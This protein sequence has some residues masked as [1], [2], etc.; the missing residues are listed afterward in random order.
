MRNIL[1]IILISVSTS[2]FSQ[3][4]IDT[5]EIKSIRYEWKLDKKTNDST[6]NQILTEYKNGIYKEEFPSFR[7]EHHE[8]P[9]INIFESKS[10]HLNRDLKLSLKIHYFSAMDGEQKYFYDKFGVIDS[11]YFNYQKDS[12]KE[13][14]IKIEKTFRK[15]GKIKWVINENGEKEVFN[16]N[17]FG[18]LQRIDVY[19]D[20]L[21][22]EINTYKN[23]LLIK[24]S[25]PNRK[26]YRKEFIYEYNKNGRL[27]KQDDDDYHFY[28]YEYNKFGIAKIEKVYKKKNIVMEY[29]IFSYNKNGLLKSKIDF[30]RNGKLRNEYVYLYK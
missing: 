15:K 1:L 13:W 20:S 16:Y 17:L 2:C 28:K 12:L 10:P 26:K 23:G 7:K 11:V 6:L 5:S 14:S 24:Q 21:L 3:I 30:W 9:F 27:L 29:T 19:K 25:Y 8:Y 22:H 4:I 18:K